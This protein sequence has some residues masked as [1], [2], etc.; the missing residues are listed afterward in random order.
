MKLREQTTI[1]A[2]A[3]E[4]WPYLVD[5]VIQAAWNPKVVSIDRA[6]DGP[7]QLGESY[8][9]IYRMS[10][11]EKMSRVTVTEM[12]P[13]EFIAF[14]HQMEESGVERSVVEGFHITP[15][16]G[17]VRLV[18]TIDI[19]KMKMPL[20]LRMLIWV[21]TRLGKEKEPSYLVRLKKM[22]ESDRA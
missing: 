13:E 8:D 4:V 7:V 11:K 21:I 2:S 1:R 18:Q 14:E 19:S 17:G 20:W 12:R 15:V 6:V 3:S 5:P 9:M 22:I 16:Y 10:G